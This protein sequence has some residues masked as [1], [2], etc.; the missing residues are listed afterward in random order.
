MR[1]RARMTEPEAVCRA[2]GARSRR[3][4]RRYDLGLSDT[5]ISG[6]E[7]LIHLQVRRFFCRNDSCE[8][9]TFT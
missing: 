8:K 6:Q 5:A 2:C 4:H 9:K 1:V 7:T 3:V